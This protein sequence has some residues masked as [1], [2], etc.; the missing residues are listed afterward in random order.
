MPGPTSNA[1]K[2]N[3][4]RRRSGAHSGLIDLPAEGC[5]LPVP[6]LPKGRKWS[7]EERKLW[8]NLWKSPQADQW[9][10]SYI[11]AVA[12]YV[13]HS[14][15]IYSAE[16]SAWQAQEFRHLGGQLGLTPAGM[17]ALGWVTR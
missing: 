9:D 3:S 16:A 14:T 1:N 12:A 10:D 6:Q 5:V 11:A 7:P 17:A 8:Q 13:C 15:A 2:P 4:R